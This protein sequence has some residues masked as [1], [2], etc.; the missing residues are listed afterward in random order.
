MSLGMVIGG[1]GAPW[2]CRLVGRR[3]RSDPCM[4]GSFGVGWY[5]C[6][7]FLVGS[8]FLQ[9]FGW[10]LVVLATLRS[11]CSPLGLSRCSRRW[12]SRILSLLLS[13]LF[14]GFVGGGL[15]DVVFSVVQPGRAQ[16]V[17]L[18]RHRRSSHWSA[19]LGLCGGS[20]VPGRRRLVPVGRPL[21]SL[22]PVGCVL[23]WLVRVWRVWVW[24]CYV[25][26]SPMLGWFCWLAVVFAT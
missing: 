9:R 17:V 10:C 15:P 25:V 11:A 3:S 23:L 2:C 4:P 18:V 19:C 7:L 1:R 22:F 24:D 12:C 14:L 21:H 20:Y 8:W 13:R 6:A 5:A 16:H 26:A